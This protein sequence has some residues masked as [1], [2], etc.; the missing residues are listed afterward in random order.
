[1]DIYDKSLEILKQITDAQKEYGFQIVL[2]GGWAIYIYNPY[3]KSR[4]IDLIVSKEDYWKL[5]NFLKSLGFSETHGEHLGKKEFLMLYGRDKIEIDV[6]DET[7]A[8][9]DVKTV[10]KNTVE[11]TIDDKAVNV[12][13]ITDLTIMKLKS[14][15]DRLG[16]AK[17]EKD[18]SDLL[19]VLDRHFR[20]IQW[21]TVTETIGKKEASAIMR[22]LLSDIEQTHRIYRLDYKRFQ[23]MKKYFRK[24]KLM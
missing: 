17:G 10:I 13:S 15:T 19:A 2:V 23:E 8:G 5:S 16:S 3:M 12:A 18:L 6:Y 9:F 1:M 20:D 22:L 4:D 24:I 7:V 21:K 14:A 11:K